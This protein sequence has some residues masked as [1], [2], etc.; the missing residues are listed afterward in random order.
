MLVFHVRTQIGFAL[1]AQVTVGTQPR[2]FVAVCYHVRAEV[3]TTFKDGAT[4][5]ASENRGIG[6]SH[7]ATTAA[8]A[9]RRWS[10]TW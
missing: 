10:S 9:A 2:C 3:R 6:A 4:D 1:V 7:A 8:G 5:G